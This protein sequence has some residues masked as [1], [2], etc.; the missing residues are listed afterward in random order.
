MNDYEYLKINYPRLRKKT[1]NKFHYAFANGWKIIRTKGLAKNEKIPALIYREEIWKNNWQN[2]SNHII[3]NGIA[4]VTKEGNVNEK[5]R[6][7]LFNEL[8]WN[9]TDDSS[10]IKNLVGQWN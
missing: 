1:V 7:Y 10:S 6:C 5:H 8:L 2:Y 4:L 3:R 9:E